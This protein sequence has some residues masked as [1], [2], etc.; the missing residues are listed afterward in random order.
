MRGPGLRLTVEPA[1][2]MVA[3]SLLRVDD[4]QPQG[5]VWSGLMPDAAA[6][7]PLVESDD[8]RGHA[9]VDPLREAD[10]ARRL[11]AALLPA[12]LRDALLTPGGTP[13]LT[14]LARGWLAQVPWD[15]LAVGWDGARVIERAVTLAGLPPGIVD[16]IATL[17]PT[18]SGVG[19]LWLVDPGPP[20]GSWPPLYPMGYPDDVRAAPAEPTDELLP[21]G[22][23]FGAEDLARQLECQA[24]DQ[25][26]YLGHVTSDPESPAASS[27][28]LSDSRGA[29]LFTAHE[30]LREPHRWPAPSKVALIGCGSDEARSQEHSGLP[31]AALRAGASLVT[32]TRWPLP[33]TTGAIRLMRAVA[34]AQRHG[35]LSTLRRWQQDELARWRTTGAADHA[36]LFWGALAS[37]DRV[38]LHGGAA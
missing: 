29:R 25:W 5:E 7:R 20:D 26:V 14:V 9:L 34:F 11:G 23:P 27:L 3:W 37:Y 19:T 4:E 12:A 30:W 22:L 13:L 10:L 15:A 33:N 38:L 17:P 36:P 24:P 1:G 32:T 31:T 6:V 8:T 35:G 16:D 28:V 18:P 21:E 2:T